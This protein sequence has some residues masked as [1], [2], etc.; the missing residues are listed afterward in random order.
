MAVGTLDGKIRLNGRTGYVLAINPDGWSVETRIPVQSLTF[1]RSLGQSVSRREDLPNDTRHT[2][3]MRRGFY[4]PV[5][6]S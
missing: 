5:S 6:T 2:R 1:D 3:H 4:A